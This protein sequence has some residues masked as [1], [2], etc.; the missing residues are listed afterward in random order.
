MGLKGENSLNEVTGVV[1]V[2]V[3]VV[4]DVVLDVVNQA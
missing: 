3:V 1:V 2:V 4:V